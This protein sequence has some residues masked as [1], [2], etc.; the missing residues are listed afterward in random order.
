MRLLKDQQVLQIGRF[1]CLFALLSSCILT[2]KTGS[3]A[4][5]QHKII[6]I[7]SAREMPLDSWVNLKGTVTV[8]PGIFASSMPNGYAIQDDS[9]GIYVEDGLARR[10]P[11]R[12]ELVTVSGWIKASNGMLYIK[13]IK[14]KKKGKGRQIVPLV[15]ATSDVHTATEG[16]ILKTSGAIDSVQ[17]DMPY[18]Y[19]VYIND[20]SGTLMVFI[21][22]GTGILNHL[23]QFKPKCTLSVTGLSASYSGVSEIV[24]RALEDISIRCTDKPHGTEK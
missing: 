21:N 3:A 12:G 18:G 22:T 11:K 23:H 6:S 7:K 5:H 17:N 2:K 20:G 13:Q 14:V 10:R 15:L 16:R 4:A 19:K 8:A 9:G 1:L 24:P